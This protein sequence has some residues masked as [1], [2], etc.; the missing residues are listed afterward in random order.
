MIRSKVACVGIGS[1]RAFDELQIKQIKEFSFVLLVAILFVFFQCFLSTTD[2]ESPTFHLNFI[3][4]FVSGDL[5]VSECTAFLGVLSGGIAEE[6]E[7]GEG[8]L[9]KYPPKDF[10]SIFRFSFYIAYLTFKQ[11]N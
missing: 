3:T 5:F 4:S 8:G 1:E 6:R 10:R 11:R 7:V 9:H 2:F